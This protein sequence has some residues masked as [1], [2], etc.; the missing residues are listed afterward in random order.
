MML[1]FRSDMAPPSDDIAKLPK[2]CMTEFSSE[3]MK[4]LISEQIAP[5]SEALLLR[6]DTLES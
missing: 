4:E 2:K 6:N 1:V 3:V 5:P